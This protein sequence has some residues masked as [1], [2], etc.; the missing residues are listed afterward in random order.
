M[1]ILLGLLASVSLVQARTSLIMFLLDSRFPLASLFVSTFSLIF[2]SFFLHLFS[3]FFSF[4]FCSLLVCEE[5]TEES[6][7]FHSWILYLLFR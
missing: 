2:A 3:F 5:M 6:S 7:N 1:G 4:S